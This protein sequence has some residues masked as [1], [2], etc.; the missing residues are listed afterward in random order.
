MIEKIAATV[1]KVAEK[2][3]EKTETFFDKLES[4]VEVA[5]PKV[6]KK[7]ESV[8]AFWES[9]ENEDLSNNQERI[10]Q[11][12]TDGERDHWKGE[13][14]ESKNQSGAYAVSNDSQEPS[15][16]QETSDGEEATTSEVETEIN[17]NEYL[18]EKQIAAL[19]EKYSQLKDKDGNPKYSDADIISMTKEYAKKVKSCKEAEKKGLE[20]LTKEEKGNYGEMRTDLDMLDKG[21]V[22]IS[23]DGVTDLKGGH[24]G[25]DGT[26]QNPDGKPPYLIIDAKYGSSQLQDTIA[27]KQLSDTWIEKNL[28]SD[29][30]KAQADVIRE[31]M[32][33]DNVGVAVARVDAG[34]N[35]TYETVDSDGNMVKELEV[36]QNA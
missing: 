30:G 26:Y 1:E 35:V 27:G 28:D 9:L 7:E 4:S 32:I 36:F 3:A 23:I 8:K 31:A 10:D 6:V 16:S 14:G 19:K 17:P 29:V 11:S 25:I 33:D 2:S 5:K 22:R 12:S 24:K 21:Y 15:E 13:R 18:T 20:N 34:S